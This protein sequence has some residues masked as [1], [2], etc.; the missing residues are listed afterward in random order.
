MARAVSR[1]TLLNNERDP[2][3]ED[4]LVFN[5][6]YH[7]LL[8][9]FQKDLNE[10]QVLLRHNEE[11]KTTFRKKPPMIGWRKARILRIIW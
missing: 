2:R 9:D 10:T 7:S 11:H 3:V 8:I 6:T 1:E 5:L 4:R